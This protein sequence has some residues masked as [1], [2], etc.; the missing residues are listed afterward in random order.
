ML[1]SDPGDIR[2][3]DIVGAVDG[4]RCY[5]NCAMGGCFECSDERSCLLHD[6][7]KEVRSDILK[8]LESTT[9]GDLVSL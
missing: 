8:Y 2:L 7:W 3:I 9:I 5:E 6:G 4:M 1:R